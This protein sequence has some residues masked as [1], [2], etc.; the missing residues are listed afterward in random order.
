[1][2]PS[3]GW[4]VAQV[5]AGVLALVIGLTCGRR[6]KRLGIGVIIA[7]LGML[8]GW[9]WLV[10]HP[11]VPVH[12]LDPGLYRYVE[13]TGAAPLFL[14]V[15]G[16][17]WGI[18]SQA[19]QKR[20]AGWSS[21]LA[22]IYFIHGG[23][24]MIQ[25]TPQYGFAETTNAKDVVLQSQEFSCVPAACATALNKIGVPTSEAEMAT[26]T[27]TRPGTGAT[28]IRA[29]HGIRSRL[30]FDQPQK[31]NVALIEVTVDELRGLSMPLITPLRVDSRQRHMVVIVRLDATGAWVADPVVGMI[32]L[33]EPELRASFTGQVLGFR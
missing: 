13:G 18:A 20:L 23:M 19:R 9:G 24:W 17:L 4:F 10:H 32:Y 25:G 27:D 7:G 12:F 22:V 3:V 33:T 30:A 15:M 28:I 16:A 5:A 11:S 6:S 1:M 31:A 2:E 21:G 8:L 14:L 29:M 26:L